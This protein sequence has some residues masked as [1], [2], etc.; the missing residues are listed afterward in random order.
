VSQAPLRGTEGRLVEAHEAVQLR[1]MLEELCCDLCRFTDGSGNGS[2]DVAIDREYWLGRPG[3]F[4]DIRVR[5]A[6]QAPYYVE[7]KYGYED[8]VLVSHMRRKYGAPDIE[9]ARLVLVLD[10]EPRTDWPRTLAAIRAAVAPQIE[11]EVWGR[12][13]F[14]E[15][16]RACYGVA[17]ESINAQDLLDVRQVID[18][19]KGRYAFG[20]DEPADYEH[21]PL[22]AE[23]LW[24]LGHHRLRQLR[25]AGRAPRQMLEPGMYKGVAVLLADICSFSAYMRDTPDAEVARDVLTSFYSKAR[26][27]IVDRGGMLY[28]FVGDE[29]VGLFG[30]PDGGEDAASQALE[31]ARALLSIGKSVSESWQRSIDRVQ[32]VSGLHIGLSLGDLQLVSLRPYSRTHIGV[33]GDTINVAARLMAQ[34]GPSEIVA[35]NSFHRRLEAADRAGFSEIE[36]V[37]AKNVGRISGWKLGVDWGGA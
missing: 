2:G 14:L 36:P 8:Q 34:A 6:G 33:L 27:Q 37:E 18:R 21:D 11:L 23:L 26:Y 20:P 30:L 15:R 17:I 25:F 9:P 12:R 28:Q 31:A 13:E 29:V 5:R 24:H 1:L 4:A 35:T 32:S 19:A 10:V 16:L 22:K 7:V 3:A